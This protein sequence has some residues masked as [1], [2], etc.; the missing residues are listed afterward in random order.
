MIAS[1]KGNWGR[2]QQLNQ[3]LKQSHR[4]VF[5]IIFMQNVSL[6]LWRKAIKSVT[7]KIHF[8]LDK[9]SPEVLPKRK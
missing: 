9:P 4:L 7:E 2:F 6:V 8:L 5:Q 3:Y 1:K